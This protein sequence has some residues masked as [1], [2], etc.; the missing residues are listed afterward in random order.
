MREIC[1]PRNVGAFVREARV[2]QGLTQ[3]QLAEKAGVSER[4]VLSLEMGDATGIRLDKL[5]AVLDA[6]GLRLFVA[7]E[8]EPDVSQAQ[9]GET[10]KSDASAG[11]TRGDA[12]EGNRLATDVPAIVNNTSYRQLYNDFL[13]HALQGDAR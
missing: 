3:R 10:G 2:S 4:S 11:A 9:D 5:L 13:S 12:R 6:V 1:Q 8:A 7:P